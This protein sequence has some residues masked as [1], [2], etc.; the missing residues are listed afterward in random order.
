MRRISR[1]RRSPRLIRGTGTTDRSGIPTSRGGP[2]GCPPLGQRG[3]AAAAAVVAVGG[4]GRRW[5][6]GAVPDH[7]DAG[8]DVRR[9]AAVAYTEFK[10][11]VR[12]KNVAEVFARGDSIEG[13]L[14]KAAPLPGQPDR[15]YQ[16]FTTERP[17]FANDDL[18]AELTA[19]RRDGARDAARPAARLPDQPADLV[20]A[21]SP[22][23]SAFYVLDVQ[24]PAGRDGRR[25][26]RRR[27][28]EARRSRDGPRH[29]RRCRRHRRSRGG[30]QR[31]RR[32]PEGPREVPAARG[33][34]AQGR[35]AGRARRAPARR[36]WRAPPPARPRC[37]SSAPAPRSS[38]R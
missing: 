35:A 5:V 8:P 23:R 2:K 20:G 7:H 27:Q 30:D 15:T 9:R 34:R 22:A 6:S 28:A 12:S 18:L 4:L 32:L 36:C 24:A 38:S 3:Q 13:Q 10:A 1:R 26:A 37:R 21:D 25:A 19:E 11:Q 33:A 17:T 31:G 14:K 16:Q 29:L